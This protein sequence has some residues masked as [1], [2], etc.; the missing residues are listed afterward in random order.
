MRKPIKHKKEH[1]T[2]L[3]QKNAFPPQRHF[4][5]S[6]CYLSSTTSPRKVL[7]E[8]HSHITPQWIRGGEESYINHP[9]GHEYEGTWSYKADTLPYSGTI[10]I[11]AL[12]HPQ[13]K[14]YSGT[15]IAIPQELS[16]IVTEIE[17]S[18]SLLSLKEDWDDQG[19]LPIKASTWKNAILTLAESAKYVLLNE[20]TIIGTPQ[21]NP[22]PESSIDIVGR[23]QNYRMIINILESA[24]HAKYYGDDYNNSSVIKG[25]LP[26]DSIKLQKFL[27]DPKHEYF[28]KWLKNLKK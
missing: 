21:I 7:H 27:S 1:R 25:E 12:K 17:K 10:V 15:D 14:I 22:G 16:E 4:D 2:A 9:V 13:N 8:N 3:F 26:I 23:M 18:K 6:S 19:A 20:N 5:N 28:S 11:Y 24:H